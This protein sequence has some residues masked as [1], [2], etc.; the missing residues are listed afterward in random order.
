MSGGFIAVTLGIIG[1]RPGCEISALLE[2]KYG[3]YDCFISANYAFGGNNAAVVIS[4]RDFIAGQRPQRKRDSE[5]VVT[6]FDLVSPL[7]VG[8]E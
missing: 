1:R 3:K 6:G 5:I 4:K 8:V 7:G 2:H